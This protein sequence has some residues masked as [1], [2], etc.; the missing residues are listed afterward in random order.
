MT[1]VAAVRQEQT[2]NKL[3]NLF[4][5]K[6]IQD[7]RFDLVVSSFIGAMRVLCDRR[8][9]EELLLLLDAFEYFKSSAH[10]PLFLRE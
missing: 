10:M 3:Q 6:R 2:L 7:T 4:T 5:R 8:N 1:A 9:A